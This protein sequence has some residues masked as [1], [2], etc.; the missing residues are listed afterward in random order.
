M[1]IITNII[2]N[3]AMLYGRRFIRVKIA[4]GKIYRG[5]GDDVRVLPSFLLTG[6]V[7]LSRQIVMAII[8]E[9]I[10]SHREGR[11]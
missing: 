8:Y 2:T 5:A 3:S 10:F 6:A 9:T 11:P 4:E 1:I 7:Q